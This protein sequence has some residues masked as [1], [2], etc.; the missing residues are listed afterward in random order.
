M[1]EHALLSTDVAATITPTIIPGH[2][3]IKFYTVDNRWRFAGPVSANAGNSGAIPATLPIALRIDANSV[4]E[5]IFVADGAYI[6]TGIKEVHSVAG[7][8]GATVDIEK[9][10]GTTAPGSGTALLTA[11]LD[12]HG[13][14]ANTVQSGT[15]ITTTASLTLAAGDRLGLVVAGTLTGLVGSVTIYV[16]PV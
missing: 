14:A 15:L 8:T 7:G 5:P 16:Q 3:N 6:F 11:A 12:V 1:P 10:T 2:G 13:V 9:L 4:S